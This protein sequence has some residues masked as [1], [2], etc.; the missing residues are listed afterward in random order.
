MKDTDEKNL[1]SGLIEALNRVTQ[2]LLKT[3]R[4]K[5]ALKI[6]INSID[7][8]SV[9]Q[10]VRTLMW[11]DT[12]LFMSVL[13]TIPDL[14]NIT[15]LGGKEIMEQLRNYPP[16]LLD[17]FLS[18]LLERIDG[19]ALGSTIDST[20]G[21]VRDVC[22]LPDGLLKRSVLD[23]FSQVGGGMGWKDGSITTI[24]FSSLEPFLNEQIRFL[25]EEA[26]KE[27]SEIRKLVDGL[28]AMVEES[29]KKNPDFVE[30]V[31]QPLL[32]VFR[33][34]AENQPNK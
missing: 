26:K 8:G 7:T 5:A 19:Q 18:G 32:K 1:Q 23:L 20:F 28:S 10:L 4:F 17:R 13:G 34:A 33:H 30:Y 14:V 25:G 29:L 16:L 9:P 24:L 6:I 12:E 3:P 27:D 11:E 22:S 31:C 21:L 2:E 15:I